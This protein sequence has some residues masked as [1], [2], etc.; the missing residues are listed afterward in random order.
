MILGARA[1][2]LNECVSDI[3]NVAPSKDDKIKENILALHE[4]IKRRGG[5]AKG[6]K[7]KGRTNTQTNVDLRAGALDPAKNQIYTA[8][9]SYRNNNREG[10]SMGHVGSLG[11]SDFGVEKTF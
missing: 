1:F 7:F 9:N 6:D 3:V 5:G 4:K 10:A 11:R 2:K 8:P